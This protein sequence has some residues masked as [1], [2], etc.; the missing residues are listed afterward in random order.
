MIQA[1]IEEL[2]NAFLDRKRPTAGCII[3]EDDHA[4]KRVLREFTESLPPEITVHNVSVNEPINSLYHFLQTEGLLAFES[5]PI[6]DF[7][8]LFDL[9]I[10]LFRSLPDG[11]YSPTPLL[12]QINMEREMLFRQHNLV[13]IFWFT[14]PEAQKVQRLAP[15]FWDWLAY[16]FYFE[17]TDPIENPTTYQ[18][19]ASISESIDKQNEYAQ[20][21]ALAELLQK[22]EAASQALPQVIYYTKLINESPYY[23]LAKGYLEEMRE[24]G[25]R[26]TLI[27]LNALLNKTPNYPTAL[28]VYQQIERYGYH[29]DVFTYTTLIRKSPNATEL[30]KWYELTKAKKLKLDE[31]SYNTILNNKALDLQTALALFEEMKTKGLQPNEITYST[32][33]NNKQLDLTKALALFEEMKTKGL[34]PNEIT[35]NTILNNKQLDLTKALALFEEMKTK[36]LQPNEITY[37]TI[38][39]NKQLDLTKALALFDEM[40]TKGLQPNEITYNTILNNKAL[41]FA[42]QMPYYQEFIKKFP[43]RKGNFKSEKNYNYLFGALFKKI[44][45]KTDWDFVKSEIYRLGLKLNDYTKSFYDNSEKMFR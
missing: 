6:K 27:T 23:S 22:T 26:P 31:I 20:R 21:K 11:T 7:V 15:D 1:Q 43:L 41:T 35:Y 24:K 18:L 4:R 28:Q 16:I 32:I 37:N 44:K 25:L 10:Y 40:K 14:Q 33:L 30:K 34:Q 42:Q 36:G 38:L 19:T 9:G 17:D 12:E 29:A 2:H 3:L 8:N 39:N 13:L 5:T 45:N